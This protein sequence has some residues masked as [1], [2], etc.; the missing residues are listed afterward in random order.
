MTDRPYVHGAE[1]AVP[2]AKLERSNPHYSPFA[3]RALEGQYPDGY[4]NASE[5]WKAAYDQAA[6]AGNPVKVALLFADN[7]EKDM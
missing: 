1:Q 5:G 7:H 4:E 6:R 3:E 2:V